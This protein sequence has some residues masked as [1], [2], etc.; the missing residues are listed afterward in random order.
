[1]VTRRNNT[2]RLLGVAA[3]TLT[4]AAGATALPSEPAQAADTIT[5]SDQPHFAYYHLDQARAK[6]Y[7]GQGVT[8][9]ILDGEVDTSAPELAGADITDKSPCTV[10]SSLRTKTHGTAMA[11]LL[12]ARDYGISPDAKILSYRLVFSDDSAG[13]DC[14]GVSGIDKN[15]SS[16]LIN[17]AINDGA[18]I[19]SISS[20]Y[21][22]GSNAL[23]WAVARAISQGIIIT[24]AA[25]NDAK[26][27]TDVTYEKWSGVIGVTAIDTDGN[28]Q[29]YS[30]WGE[31]VVS[32]AVGGPVTIRDYS[33]GELVTTSGTSAST[34]LVAGS[35]ALARQKWPQATSNQL[36]QLLIHTGTN[37][38]HTWNKYTGYGGVAPGAMVNTDPSRY[39]DENPLVVKEGGSSPTPDEVKQYT[40][41]VVSPFEIAYDNSYTYRGLDE[42]MIGDSRNPY[43]THLGTSPRYHGK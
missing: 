11:S 27:E 41:G 23:K 20:S 30:S 36:L 21:A 43:P 3:S 7:T 17:T 2:A 16:S 8:I 38:D 5:A 22:G 9:A 29:D 4:L 35:L 14:S 32:A 34:P 15:E 10:T 25:G 12:V 42:N 40:D 18:Q 31:G 28:F 37:P 1:M 24:A 6:G 19:I 39:P 26:N 33:S 13:S